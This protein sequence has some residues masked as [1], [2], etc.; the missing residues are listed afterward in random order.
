MVPYF[1][2][3][4]N[5]EY[6]KSIREDM[7]KQMEVNIH[8]LYHGLQIISFAAIDDYAT[9]LN[10]ENNIQIISKKQ[11]TRNKKIKKQLKDYKI[12]FKEYRKK[13]E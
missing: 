4:M 6:H 12:S 1:Q 13:K 7:Q 5:G 3:S 2:Q 8:K 9:E 10:K 11:L